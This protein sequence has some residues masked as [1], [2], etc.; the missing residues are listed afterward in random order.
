MGLRGDA[1]EQRLEAEAERGRARA[2]AAGLAQHVA[3]GE[4]A[5][6]ADGVLGVG[7]GEAGVAQRGAH[8]IEHGDRLGRAHR[9]R[10]QDRHH[11]RVAQERGAQRAR[12]AGE[13]RAPVDVAAGVGGEGAEHRGVQRVEQVGL[14]AHV[15][16]QAHGLDAEAGAQAA[17]RQRLQ[18]LLVDQGQRLGADA[19]AGEGVGELFRGWA[20]VGSRHGL[21]CKGV[22]LTV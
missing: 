7:G 11:A 17:H 22:R 3:D 9:L 13:Q 20:G 18:P 16:I 12:E 19:F 2:G 15:V 5:D 10:R 4:D 6:G 8:A 1:V 14:V 21:R